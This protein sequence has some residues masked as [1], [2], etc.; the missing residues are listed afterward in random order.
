[1][2][3][4]KTLAVGLSLA[5]ALMGACSTR[6][7]VDRSVDAVHA[8]NR[9]VGES[10]DEATESPRGTVVSALTFPFRLVANVFEALFG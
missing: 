5:F 10:V 3:R 6:G 9:T 1:M 8:T 2:Q 7:P 4:V